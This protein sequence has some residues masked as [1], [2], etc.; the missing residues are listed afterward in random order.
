MHSGSTAAAAGRR[1]AA[2]AGPQYAHH[3]HWQ[4]QRVSDMQLPRKPRV[5]VHVAATCICVLSA[6][7]AAV[8]EQPSCFANSTVCPLPPHDCLVPACV[9]LH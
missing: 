5:P 9:R 6:L 3:Q 8:L 2:A 7:P 4:Q 1:A